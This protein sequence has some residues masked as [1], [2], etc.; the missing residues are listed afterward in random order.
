MKVKSKGQT[1]KK[2]IGAAYMTKN[3]LSKVLTNHWG[4]AEEKTFHR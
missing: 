4:V 1:K 2:K 3:N